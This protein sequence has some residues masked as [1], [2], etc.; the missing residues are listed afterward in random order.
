M[1]YLFCM[2]LILTII[3][4]KEIKEEQHLFVVMIHPDNKKLAEYLE[5]HKNIWPEVEAGFK[6]AGY[7][8]IKLFRY[9]HMVVMTVTVPFGADLGE[10]G[11]LA[12]SSDKRCAE[13]NQL[14]ETYQTGIPGTEKGQK[15]VEVTEFYSFK[16]PD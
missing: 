15:W 2:L 6:K 14:M 5:Y 9:E 12:E 16:N 10:M 7:R 4:C 8:E 13:W 3:S 1:R 11:R